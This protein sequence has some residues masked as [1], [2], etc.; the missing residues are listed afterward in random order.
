MKDSFIHGYH[1]DA[2]WLRSVISN[3]INHIELS[4]PVNFSNRCFV[5]LL[6]DIGGGQ[7]AMQYFDFTSINNTKDSVIVYTDIDVEI[8]TDTFHCAFIGQ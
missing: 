1:L 5:G 4:F 7:F 3:R 2:Q 8:Y 6:G